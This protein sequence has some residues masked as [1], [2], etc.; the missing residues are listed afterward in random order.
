[1]RTFVYVCVCVCV[2]VCVNGELKILKILHSKSSVI[3]IIEYNKILDF[4]VAVGSHGSYV[5]RAFPRYDRAVSLP[6]GFV[7]M[8]LAS[9]TIFQFQAWL[10]DIYLS[11]LSFLFVRSVQRSMPLLFLPHFLHTSFTSSLPSFLPSFL[12]F[13]SL[14]PT[15]GNS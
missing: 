6:C 4:H 5:A 15:L 11:N 3:I 9:C 2:C 10:S 13:L 1:M 8:S 14:L 12:S 7:S